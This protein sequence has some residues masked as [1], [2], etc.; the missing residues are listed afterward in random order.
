MPEF[1]WSQRVHGSAQM[2]RFLAFESDSYDKVHHAEEVVRL[3]SPSVVWYADASTFEDIGTKRRYVIPMIN[4]PLHERL[5][6]NKA[7]ELP[8]PIDDPF[9]I[10]VKVPDGFHKARATMLS[11]EPRVAAVP[12]EATVAAGKARVMFPGLKLFRTLVMEFEPC[13]QYTIQGDEFTKAI[14]GER[15]VPTPLED[16]VANMAVVEALFRS[17]REN[18]WVKI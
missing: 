10:E 12:L 9:R 3:D 17:A 6:R 1:V 7:N 11:W 14:R 13:D 2:F 8:P 15:D 5:R 18:A 16:S 4:P